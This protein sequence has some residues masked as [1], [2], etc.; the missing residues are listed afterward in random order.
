MLL[1]FKNDDSWTMVSDLFRDE[2]IGNATA[3]N[4]CIVAN[5]N[6]VNC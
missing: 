4:I 3:Q 1:K 5:E 2:R 6:Q